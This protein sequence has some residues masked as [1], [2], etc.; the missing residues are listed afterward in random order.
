MMFIEK[1]VHLLIDGKKKYCDNPILFQ[2]YETIQNEVIK[3]NKKLK[4]INLLRIKDAKTKEKMLQ[5][6]E[7]MNKKIIFQ[8]RQIDYSFMDKI[9]KIKKKKEIY[10]IKLER[11]NKNISIEDFMYDL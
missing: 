7:K 2:K 11:K 3:E 9:N 4:F 8:T 6:A 10:N 5:M 1:A